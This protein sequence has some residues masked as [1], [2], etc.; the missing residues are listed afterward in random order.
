MI[1]IYDMRMVVSPTDRIRVVEN[2][3]D[4]VPI[5]C[6]EPNQTIIPEMVAAKI[7]IANT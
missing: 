2:G 1:A 7:P 5:D 6:S 3:D 4:T